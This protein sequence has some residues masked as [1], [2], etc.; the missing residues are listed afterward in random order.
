M[1]RESP[2][3]LAV[4]GANTHDMRLVEATLESVP[5]ERPQPRPKARQHLCADKGYDYPSVRQTLREWGYTIHIKSRGEE[6]P[7]ESRCPA[8]AL[9]GGWS[10][11]HIRG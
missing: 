1:A 8:I 5:V 6:E 9:A 4:E 7:R 10:S 3:G 2:I 11:E